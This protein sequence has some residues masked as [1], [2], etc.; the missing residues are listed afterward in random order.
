MCWCYSK[1]YNNKANNRCSKKITFSM[2]GVFGLRQRIPFSALGEEEIE[3]LNTAGDSTIIDLS[4][5]EGAYSTF[6]IA[7]GAEAETLLSAGLA[8][9]GTEA[10]TGIGVPLAVGTLLATGIAYGGYKI[11]EY[12]HN[13]DLNQAQIKAQKHNIINAINNPSG[14]F[15][16]TGE[17]TSLS[18]DTNKGLNVPGTKYIGP[19]NILNKG[20]P[21]SLSDADALKHDK[22]YNSAQNSK[23]IFKADKTLLKEASDHIAE[24]ISGSGS[25]KDT[26]QSGISGVGIG[27]KNIVE[28]SI[29]GDSLYPQ[30][31]G[32][33]H[34]LILNLKVKNLKHF[35]IIF[36]MKTKF[37]IGVNIAHI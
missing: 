37:S 36:L 17:K 7:E 11:Y 16:D 30:F 9:A 8:T 27:I 33:W 26:I 32:K 28:E 4:G 24:G 10:S 13:K 25:I 34:H 31:S 6:A 12:E 20:D 19:G 3:L 22:A 1:N 5:V 21:T 15:V 18:Y 29:L 35:G 23:Q 14:G 2:S